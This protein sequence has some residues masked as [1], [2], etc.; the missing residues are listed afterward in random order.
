MRL[1]GDLLPYAVLVP[2]LLGFIVLTVLGQRSRHVAGWLGTALTALSFV[3]SL[4]LFA[5]VLEGGEMVVTPSWSYLTLGEGDVTFHFAAGPLGALMVVLVS[6]ISSLVHLYSIGYMAEDT[7][8]HVFFQYLSLFTFAMLG[9]VMSVNWL[10]LY[11]FW[12]LVGLASFLLIGF[13]YREPAARAAAKKA[14]I[15][16]RFGDIG[17]FAAIILIYV[18]TKSF[19][20]ADTFQAVLSG[21]L[22]GGM[23]TAIA[24]LIFLGAAGKSGQFPLHVWL[25]DAMEGPTPASALIHAATMVAAGVYLVAFTYPLFVAA[26]YALHVVAIIGVFTAFLAATMALVQSDIKRVL[27]YSTI[28]QLGYMMLAL[29]IGSMSAAIFHLTTHAFFKALLFLAAGNI[30][31]AVGTNDMFKMGGLWKKMPTTGWVFLIGALALSGIPPLAGYFSKEAIIGQSLA[32]GS[33]FFVLSVA[34]AFLTALYMGRLFFIVFLGEPREQGRT[35][36]EPGLTMRMPTIILA[37]LTIFGGLLNLPG[38]PFLTQFLNGTD[39]GESA[40]HLTTSVTVVGLSLFAFVFAYLMFYK[41]ALNCPLN[42]TNR[43]LYRLL[44]NRYYI[45]AFYEKGVG[46]LVRLLGMLAAFIDRWI[47][48]GLVRTVAAMFTGSG[49]VLAELQ[50]GQVQRYNAIALF[51][52]FILLLMYT[53]FTKGVLG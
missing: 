12:E 7:R 13:Y 39:E 27:A 38:K 47:I 1:D 36:H 24:L 18:Q 19:D 33:S 46:G 32:Y 16:T 21:D 44:A 51:A 20:V 35:A 17:L 40:L 14:F 52:L 15:T 9:L 22:S 2:T 31:H 25:P 42:N 49:K 41:G 28:S 29:G 5:R 11:V 53:L 48:G 10:L 34:T 4:L 37:L 6:G 8:R 30:I 43:A 45:D 26:P 3:F 23:L 50:N